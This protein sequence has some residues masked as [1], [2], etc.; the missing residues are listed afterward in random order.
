MKGVIYGSNNCDR[1]KGQIHIVSVSTM[2][3]VL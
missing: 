2:G 3:D 1:N